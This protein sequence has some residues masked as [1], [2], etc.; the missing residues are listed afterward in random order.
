MTLIMK[1]LLAASLILGLMGCWW[2]N[3]NQGPV[4]QDV[5]PYVVYA[6]PGQGE[7]WD[8]PNVLAISIAS[9]EVLEMGLGLTMFPVQDGNI[10][11][12]PGLDEYTYRFEN[13]VQ[14]LTL[15]LKPPLVV[16]FANGGGVVSATLTSS[17]CTPGNYVIQVFVQ[18]TGG[19]LINSRMRIQVKS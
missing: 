18:R 10:R 3:T 19:D 16:S 1:R 9:S 15:K 2:N 13:N 4:I 14:C 8:A 5:L 17:N 12:K 6:V 11:L 7:S